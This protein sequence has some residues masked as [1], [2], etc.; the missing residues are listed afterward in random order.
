M[1]AVGVR[2]TLSVSLIALLTGTAVSGENPRYRGEIDRTIEF[3]PGTGAV[4]EANLLYRGDRTLAASATEDLDFAGVLAT[5]LGATITAGELLVI[6]IEAAAGNTN[7]VE[8][9]PTA[10]V[11]FL[12]PFKALTDRQ[13]VKP[14]EFALFVSRTGWG[15]TGATADKWTFTNAAA[16]T[17]VTYT[18]TVIGR[19]VAA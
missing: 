3:E 10:T 17:P 14:G 7:N 4:D 16:G 6:C 12:G 9:G 19:T 11:G 8:F 13:I 2:A 1:S 5:P 15:I 18:L